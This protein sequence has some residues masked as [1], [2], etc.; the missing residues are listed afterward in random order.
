MQI[1]RITSFENAQDW[2]Y[3]KN[4]ERNGGYKKDYTSDP[5]PKQLSEFMKCSKWCDIICVAWISC[6]WA[7]LRRAFLNTYMFLSLDLFSHALSFAVLVAVW[8]GIVV[9]FANDLIS[10]VSAGT[11]Y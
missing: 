9:W 1:Q 6:S 10:G 5:S 2:A 11:Y 3:Q 4:E 7:W 8:S